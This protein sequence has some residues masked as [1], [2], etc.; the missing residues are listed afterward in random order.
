MYAAVL[1]HDTPVTG[2]TK[3]AGLATRSVVGFVTAK[4]V[5]FIELTKY[6]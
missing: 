4:V 3:V 2:K 5:L 6:F 1:F